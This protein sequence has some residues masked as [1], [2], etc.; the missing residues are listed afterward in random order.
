M[1]PIHGKCPAYFH[2]SK[3]QRSFSSKNR[4]SEGVLAGSDH[5]NGGQSDDSPN[6]PRHR[7]SCSSY[8]HRRD[9]SRSGNG[10]C[11][12]ALWFD[13]T[14]RNLVSP[15][16]NYERSGKFYSIEPIIKIKLHRPILLTD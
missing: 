5:K 10:L 13:P 1:N 3:T 15:V 8:H 7:A 2:F 12:G 11:P 16:L 4:L 6:A 9:Y 14:D